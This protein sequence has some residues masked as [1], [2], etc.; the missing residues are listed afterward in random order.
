VVLLLGARRLSGAKAS[1]VAPPLL[2]ILGLA[3]LLAG[4]FGLAVFAAGT[5]G[6][7]C[8]FVLI[9]TLALPPQLAPAGDVHRLSAGM[10]A[11]GYTLSCL[12]PPLGGMLWDISAMPTM[13]FAANTLSAAV[14]FAAALSVRRA[15]LAPVR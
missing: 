9:L 14:V 15:N 8:A 3:G 10:F 12:V 4:R 6:F 2:G 5:I 7:C 13:A 1:Y 11:I